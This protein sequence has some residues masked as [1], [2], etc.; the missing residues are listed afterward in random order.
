MILPLNYKCSQ[1]SLPLSV[2]G[3][4]HTQTQANEGTLRQ[5]P[6]GSGILSAKTR[7]E[8]AAPESQEG[9]SVLRMARL[10]AGS[11]D[12]GTPHLCQQGSGLNENDRENQNATTINNEQHR[13]CAQT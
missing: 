4:C 10:R 1:S 8:T 9:L 12:E 13:S 2:L 6:R 3:V 7:Q 11:G 5:H